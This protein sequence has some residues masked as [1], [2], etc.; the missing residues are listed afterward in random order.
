MTDDDCGT[1]SS[2][3]SGIA[4]RTT[5]GNYPTKYDNGLFFADYTR[6]CIWFAPASSA[7]AAPDFT[8]VEQFANLR[9]SGDTSGGAVWVGTTPAGDIIYADYDRNEIRAIHYYPALPPNAAFTATPMSGPT[10]LDVDFDA[11]TSNDPNG[12]P[13]SYAVGPRRR[14]PVRRR[15]R[16]SAER[17]YT[18]PGN[19]T[20]GLKVTAGGDTDTAFKTINVGT[21]A[22]GDHH[23]G[24]PLPSRGRSA[25]RS[26]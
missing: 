11:S 14:R 5:A 24:P 16:G 9:R 20:V 1:G 17:V 21:R 13:I 6:R 22:D 12:D 2:S 19:V 26:P 15:D 3:I 23:R 8:S 25:T 7:T 4:F 10:P 18:T